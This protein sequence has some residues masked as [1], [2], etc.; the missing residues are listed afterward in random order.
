MT[1]PDTRALTLTWEQADALERYLVREC[2]RLG[3]NLRIRHDD[4]WWGRPTATA[5]QADLRAL[6]DILDALRR[7]VAR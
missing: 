7:P 2:E 6:A 3:G 1:P 5:T 4:A